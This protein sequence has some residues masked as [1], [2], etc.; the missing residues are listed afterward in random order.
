MLKR[1][2][3]IGILIILILPLQSVVSIK[4]NAQN[5]NNSEISSQN[6][7]ADIFSMINK[8]NHSI[9]FGYLDKV[10]SFGIRPVGSENCRLAAEYINDEFQNLALD[11]SMEEWK[12]RKYRCR[13]VVATHEGV[14][15]NSDAV[16]VLT[17]HLDTKGES[18]GANDDASGVA[19]ILTI[20]NIT[21]KYH[22][23]HTIKFVIV[24]G[25]EI[26]TFGSFDYAEKAYRRNENII[27][28]INLDSIGN[29]TC[30][31]ILQARVPDRSH[32]L[33]NSIKEISENYEE[34]IDME[35]QLTSNTLIDSQAFVDYGYDGTWN[36]GLDVFFRF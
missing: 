34:I 3:I 22:F 35:V 6:I 19:T 23:N 14:D 16:I 12:Y 17:A 8:I 13:N 28:N 5:I 11:S 29:S 33:Y 25:E 18:V 31:N 36:T 1:F 10:V 27:A 20:A 2:V 26:G 9:L 4:N 24:S 15:S 21:S 30:G 7:D 32:N